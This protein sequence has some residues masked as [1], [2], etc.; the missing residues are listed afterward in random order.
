MD[1]LWRVLFS[2]R[3]VFDELRDDLQV[4]LPI[5]TLLSFTFIAT[6]LLLVLHPLALPTAEELDEYRNQLLL[7]EVEPDREYASARRKELREQLYGPDDSMV[8]RVPKARIEP[9]PIHLVEQPLGLL[10]FLLVHGTSFWVLGKMMKSDL[11]WNQ[12]FG[13]VCWSELPLI[14]VLVLDVVLLAMGTNSRLLF[15]YSFGSAYIAATTE[16]IWAAWTFVILV[17]GLRSWTAKGLGAC[18]GWVLASYLQI[19]LPMVLILIAI[20]SVVSLV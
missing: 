3:S 11:R 5:F 12:W 19:I 7:L 9:R 4:A 17:Q 8:D 18:I 13:L 14:V 1:K 16:A 2:P 20:A 10:A 6:T 15:S